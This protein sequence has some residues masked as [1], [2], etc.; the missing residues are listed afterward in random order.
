MIRV[1]IEA[2]S[3][4]LHGMSSHPDDWSRVGEAFDGAKS[5]LETPAV[6]VATS[7][8]QT[9]SLEGRLGMYQLTARIGVGGMGEVYRA[10]DT[11]R[12]RDIAIRAAPRPC[13][14]RPG[15][16]R[17]E[18]EAHAVA[19]LNHPHIVSIFST[20]EA[21]GVRAMTMQLVEGRTLAHL[22]P[23]MRLRMIRVVGYAVLFPVVALPLTV[24]FGRTSSPSPT[25]DA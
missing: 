3:Q 4:T 6:P 2:Q 1:G 16:A 23:P 18:R 24:L 21:D 5:F 19:A 17:F 8:L 14:A 10:R 7:A 13:G 9:M 25:A 15:R 22:I 20:E 12:G 11:R